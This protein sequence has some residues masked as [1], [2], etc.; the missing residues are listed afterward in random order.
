MKNGNFFYEFAHL[1]NLRESIHW[2]DELVRGII[3]KK[4]ILKDIRMFLFN[5]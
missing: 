4:S 2:Y 3:Q 1:Q 5:F